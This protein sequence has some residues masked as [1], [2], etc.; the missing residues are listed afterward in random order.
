MIKILSLD[1]NHIEK[2][3]LPCHEDWSAGFALTPLL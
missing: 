2:F 1:A 3:F